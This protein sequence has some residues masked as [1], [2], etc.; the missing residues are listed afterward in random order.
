MCM[1]CWQVSVLR[2]EFGD[3]ASVF[4]TVWCPH[5]FLK[6]C[7]RLCIC[8]SLYIYIYV[9]IYVTERCLHAS[10]GKFL[11]SELVHGLVSVLVVI[12]VLVFPMRSVHGHGRHDCYRY[13]CCYP[14][15]PFA[16]PGLSMYATWDFSRRGLASR[17]FK[18]TSTI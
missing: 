11:Q 2:R 9:H 8:M 12:V 6:Y 3:E 15:F 18:R 13:C 4:A 7:C 17:G 14:Q 5:L 16:P 1:R 10:S